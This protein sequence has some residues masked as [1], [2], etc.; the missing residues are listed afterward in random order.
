MNPTRFA[1]CNIVMTAPKGMKDCVNVH[2]CKCKYPNGSPVVITAWTPTP[3]ELVK[4]N[5]GHPIYL[6]IV[7]QSMPPVAVMVEDP[8]EQSTNNQDE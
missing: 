6:H 8:F 5:L 7:G 3:E 4:I 2:A 1:Q